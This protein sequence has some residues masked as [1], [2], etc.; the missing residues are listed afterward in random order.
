LVYS[1]DHLE[2]SIAVRYDQP[3]DVAPGK[4]IFVGQLV[5]I[6]T[7]EFSQYY[8]LDFGELIG[9]GI[10][11]LNGGLMSLANNRAV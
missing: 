4:V 7:I 10:P 8:L 1:S 11:S 2:R 9:I 5:M 3:F 6:R